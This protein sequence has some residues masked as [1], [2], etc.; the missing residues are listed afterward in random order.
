MIGL[1]VERA[2][3][4][5]IQFIGDP[6]TGEISYRHGDDRQIVEVRMGVDDRER[7]IPCIICQSVDESWEQDYPA[8]NFRGLAAVA[9]LYAADPEEQ[10]S[11]PADEALRLARVINGALHRIDLLK[12]LTDASGGALHFSG[13][14][15]GIQHTA[16]MEQRHWLH[17]WALPLYVCSLT[18]NPSQDPEPC[19]LK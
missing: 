12:A 16:G 17:V 19:P 6:A 10:V 9:F 5:W 18:L 14:T 4:T 2:L 1:D 15:G 11:G 3:A 7:P 8:A 13:F